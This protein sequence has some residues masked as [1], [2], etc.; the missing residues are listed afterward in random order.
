MAVLT[1]EDIKNNYPNV[2]VCSECGKEFNA[3]WKLKN[4]LRMKHYIQQK[5]KKENS[6][7]AIKPSQINLAVSPNKVVESENEINKSMNRLIKIMSKQFEIL[8]L[9]KMINNLMGDGH[10]SDNTLDIIEKTQKIREQELKNLQRIKEQIKEELEEQGIGE[11]DILQ[12]I[13]S[14][15]EIIKMAKEFLIKGGK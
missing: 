15:P 5:P 7:S 1:E 12:T 9:Q 3:E 14:N 8:N 13:L 4:H 2:Y 11:E 10:K 6:T